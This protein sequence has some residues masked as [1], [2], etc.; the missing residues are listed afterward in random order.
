MKKSKRRLDRK[1][2]QS[3]WKKRPN[4]RKMKKG[5]AKSLKQ[6]LKNR[7][8][9]KRDKSNWQTKMRLVN[10]I[11]KRRELLLNMS[12]SIPNSQHLEKICFQSLNN[13]HRKQHL[14]M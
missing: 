10:Q 11:R 13:K 14:P 1:T 12:N 9:D 4:K 6:W 7:G 3:G 5:P 2:K 8:S